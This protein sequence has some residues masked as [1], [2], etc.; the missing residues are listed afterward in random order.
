MKQ[1]R[2]PSS[3]CI[4]MFSCSVGKIM[5]LPFQFPLNITYVV[6]LP[7]ICIWTLNMSCSA[8]SVLLEQRAGADDSKGSHVNLWVSDSKAR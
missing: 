2:A 3:S 7:Y 1:N 5:F 6:F 4:N 8:V